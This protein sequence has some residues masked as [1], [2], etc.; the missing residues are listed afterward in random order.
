MSIVN[1]ARLRSRLLTAAFFILVVACWWFFAP[2]QVGGST[3]YVVTK[4]ISMEPRFHTGDLAIVRPA[5]Q[6]KVGDI[7]AYLEHACCTRGV[8][9]RII[10]IHGDRY[11]FKGDNNNF[12]D[13]DPSDAR[14]TVRQVVDACAARWRRGSTSSTRPVVA[15]RNLR[16]AR[17]VPCWSASARSAGAVGAAERARRRH[18]LQ[19]TRVVNTTFRSERWASHRLRLR[20]SPRRLSP[21]RSFSCSGCSRS[22]VLRTSRPT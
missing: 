16:A 5:D 7:V 13:P 2:T 11:T 9:H 17:A 4:G 14:S 3:R 18:L 8:L 20:A 22:R 6:Y 19:E 10:A 15:R 12:I 21:P 1:R